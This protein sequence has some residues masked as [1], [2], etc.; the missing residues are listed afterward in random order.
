MTGEWWDRPATP[1]TRR[2]LKGRELVTL[3][4]AM[5]YLRRPSYEVLA[6]VVTGDLSLV[7]GNA[8]M[9]RAQDLRDLRARLSH[10][11]SGRPA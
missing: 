10:G 3:S 5:W 7:G 4:E 9:F 1:G 2:T 8:D 6:Y 11:W